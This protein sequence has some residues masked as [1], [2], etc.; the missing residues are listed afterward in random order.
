MSG[1]IVQLLSKDV[2]DSFLTKRAEITF[3][4][5][6]A[7]HHTPFSMDTIEEFFNK[8]PNFGEE[9]FCELSK[10]GDLINNM[11]LKI[12]IPKVHISNSIDKDL[13]S[14]YSANDII[15]DNYTLNIGNMIAEYDTIIYKFKSFSK[16]SMVYWRQIKQL[17]TNN[18][19]NYNNVI[20]LLSSLTGIQNDNQDTYD[21]YNEFTNARIGKTLLHFNF[22]ILS[23]IQ[24]DYTSY[25]KSVYN[26]KLNVEYKTKINKYLDDYIFYQK[27]YVEHLI[28]TRDR[29]IK[30]K[31]THDSK[32]YR[33]AWVDKIA[34][35]LIQ[36]VTLDIGGQRFDYHDRDT[37]N[38]WYEMATKIEFMDTY[39]ALIG[40]TQILTSFDSNEK[41]QYELFI[42]LPFGNILHNSQTIPCVATRYQDIII[43]V[44]LCELEK[45]CFFEPDEFATYSS[46]ININEEVNIVNMS[47]FVDYIHLS[48]KERRNFSSKTVEM[49]VEQHRILTFSSIYKQNVLLPL[50]FNNA[51]KD[52]FWTIQKKYNIDQLK[53]WAD[54][55]NF[56]VFPAL[57]NTTGQQEP[58]IGKIYIELNNS[59]I[60][61]NTLT[62]YTDY[63]NG[64]CEIYHSKYYNGTYKII[65]IYTQIIILDSFD[66]IYPDIIKIKLFKKHKQKYNTID[67]ENILIYGNDLIT[68]RDPLFYTNVQDRKR[69]KS[70]PNIHKYS[71][72]LEPEKFQP[73]GVLNFNVIKNKQLQLSFDIKLINH[74]VEN[75]DKIVVKI[76]G[77]NYNTSVTEKGYTNLVYG[78]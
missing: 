28:S 20:S 12:T 32:Y 1:S 76:I 34:L 14:D 66:F 31:E 26:E 74:I 2:K 21:K 41:P 50:D 64:S 17:L 58:Y 33:F 57:I 37:L 73:S 63:I 75:N 68:L 35:A 24:Y 38:D 45:C 47:L 67:K 54:F 59:P 27:K 46:N 49:L 36:S 16:A 5:N 55:D 53:L 10:Y 70:S 23:H 18:N 3:F 62:N 11:V 29:F 22:S 43:N 48:D 8:T 13:L 51:V 42:P 61:N 60:F 19:S 56:D 72:A 6:K 39:N 44:K 69:T 7:K 9:V 40:N 52:I 71:I 15:D 78:I 30:H 25:S 4:M 77:K 65:G